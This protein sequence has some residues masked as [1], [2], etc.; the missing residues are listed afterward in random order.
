MGFPVFASG[1]VL[2]ASDMN[3][4]GLW[5]V[6]S[7]TIGSGV[8][9]VV[10]SSAFSAEYDNYRVI[11]TGGTASPGGSIRV[12]LSN[13]T[14]ST[15]QMFGFFGAY[16]TAS[17]TAYSPAATTSWTDAIR[18]DSTQY[19]ASIDLYGPFRTAATLGYVNTMDI[20]NVY[21]FSLRDSSTNSSTGF[22]I[23]PNSGTMT[24]GTIRV[25]GYR[26]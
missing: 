3:A 11:I 26:N 20:G 25:Y 1:D 18:A 9:S 4:V 5:L 23:T 13:S 22:T 8:S 7:Q 15:Y 12:Q 2:N 17:L 6:K 14:G 21:N 24:G 19:M 10:V 16:G